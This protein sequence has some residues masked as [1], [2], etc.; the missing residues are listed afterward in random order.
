MSAACRKFPSMRTI[1]AFLLAIAA[2][3]AL[4]GTVT[5][6]WAHDLP[7]K[8]TILMYVKPQDARLDVLLRVPMEALTEVQ[9]P[10]RGPGYLDLE[11]ADRALLDAAHMY[12]TENM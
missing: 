7:G 12:M 4:V 6:A 1:R 10:L 9:F 5:A 3:C 11:Q 8:L 2:A